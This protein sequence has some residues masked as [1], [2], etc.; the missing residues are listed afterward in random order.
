IDPGFGMEIVEAAALAADPLA[1]HQ[2]DA[3]DSRDGADPARLADRMTARLGE[4]AVQRP[5]SRQSHAPERASYWTEAGEDGARA[6]PPKPDP[7]RP[8]LMLTRPEPVEAVSQLPD[9]P[10]RLFV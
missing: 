9:G 5:A 1:P 4:G 6:D 7:R 10:P 2:T 3:M 8:L